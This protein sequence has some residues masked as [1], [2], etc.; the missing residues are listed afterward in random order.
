MTYMTWCNTWCFTTCFVSPDGESTERCWEMIRD[1][2]HCC[3][4]VTMGSERLRGVWQ[5]CRGSCNCKNPSHWNPL[6]RLCSCAVVHQISH[7]DQLRIG[8]TQL[9]TRASMLCSKTWWQV[10]RLSLLHHA[11]CWLM[12]Y[13]CCISYICFMT[14]LIHEWNVKNQ[15]MLLVFLEVLTCPDFL[16]FCSHHRPTM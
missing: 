4:E 6:S 16:R 1:H 5:W 12:L 15:G 3:A 11:M 7:C 13:H 14:S 9:C 8:R 10:L 2:F